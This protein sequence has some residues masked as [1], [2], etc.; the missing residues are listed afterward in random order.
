MPAEGQIAG[1]C[2]ETAGVGIP[3]DTVVLTAAPAVNVAK[4]RGPLALRT[5]PARLDAGQVGGLAR[6]ALC[7]EA[8]LTPKPGL[9]DT[10]SGGAHGDMTLE[11]LLASADALAEPVADCFG[12]GQSLP[13][14]ESLRACLGRIGRAGEARMLRATGGVN[15][16]RG[17]LWA[18]G[19]LAAGLGATG[20]LQGAGEFAAAIAAIAD[21]DPE[22]SRPS[23]G[24][25]VRQGYGAP[26]ARGEALAGFPHVLKVALPALRAGRGSGASEEAARLDALLAVMARMEDTCLLHRGGPR[27][28]SAVR[29][30]ASAVLEVGGCG[31]PCGRERLAALD[32]YCLAHR[33]SAGGSGDTL[34]AALFLDAAEAG[35]AT[36]RLSAAE[37]G[38]ATAHLSASEAGPRQT[39]MELP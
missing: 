14:G 35:V 30:M 1:V 5:A 6:S 18:L 27:G 23:H 24:T 32:D 11:L 34:A 7:A 25:R 38:V 37:A 22:S 17:A 15:T 19:L 13:V 36:S 21:P 20:T 33:L 12:A 28:L 29:R 39:D 3:P 2:P 31:T 4:A 8:R 16:H 10:R 26:G 9:V